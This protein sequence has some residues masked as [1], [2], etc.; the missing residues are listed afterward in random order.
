MPMYRTYSDCGQHVHAYHADSELCDSGV[1]HWFVQQKVPTLLSA[2]EIRTV[3]AGWKT[4][5][6]N[7]TIKSWFTKPLGGALGTEEWEL[8]ELNHI[9]P[10]RTYKV[11]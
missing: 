7:E 8:L 2:G 10:L 1:G 4:K 3:L 11:R 9:A 5:Q 6:T